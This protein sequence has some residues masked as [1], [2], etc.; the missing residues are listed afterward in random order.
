MTRENNIINLI[1]KGFTKEQIKAEALDCSK[2]E[3]EDF[4]AKLIPISQKIIS[5]TLD[6]FSEAEISEVLGISNTCVSRYLGCFINSKSSLYDEKIAKKI[7]TFRQNKSIEHKQELYKKLMRLEEN[8]YD[9]SAIANREEIIGFRKFQKIVIILKKTLQEGCLDTVEKLAKKC[10]LAKPDLSKILRK[11]DDLQ[12]LNNYFTLEEQEELVSYYE[13]KKASQRVTN[14]ELFDNKEPKED[15]SKLYRRLD[16]WCQV[17]LTYRLSLYNLC[18]ILKYQDREG[19]KKFMLSKASK[20]YQ[21]GLKYLFEIEKAPVDYLRDK[22]HLTVPELQVLLE[23]DA[24]RRQYIDDINHIAYCQMS[25]NTNDEKCQKIMDRLTD[26]DYKETIKK[27]L[28]AGVFWTEEE[29]SNVVKYKIKY[30]L[31]FRNIPVSRDVIAKRCPEYL[32]EELASCNTYRDEFF[33]RKLKQEHK[34]KKYE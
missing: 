13:S 17:A 34:G 8:N 10:G 4:F 19:L 12:I 32:K 7:K 1:K 6:G 5:L 24:L 2:Q 28:K 27:H 3:I 31:T 21:M 25:G 15:Y 30:C 23:D 18:E 29:I 22:A 20:K 9:L 33:I 16:Y 14:V 26:R 11:K